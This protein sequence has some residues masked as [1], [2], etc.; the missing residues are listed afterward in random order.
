MDLHKSLQNLVG[1]H[2]LNEEPDLLFNA[3]R[4]INVRGTQQRVFILE[5]VFR[6]I[7]LPDHRAFR[8]HDEFQKVLHNVK[9]VSTAR[10]VPAGVPFYGPSIKCTGTGAPTYATKYK[11]VKSQY[12]KDQPTITLL[13][14][15]VLL[16]H[17][18]CKYN[19]SIQARCVIP[20]FFVF[21]FASPRLP[22]CWTLCQPS[23]SIFKSRSS[24][25][26]SLTVGAT[27]K[28]A[29]GRGRER[30]LLKNRT[31]FGELS[32]L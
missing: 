21:W 25:R 13:G 22:L 31:L 29:R 26:F 23:P 19:I 8:S 5:V 24:K 3:E 12:N 2:G 16:M 1:E 11:V 28:V 18:P 32:I 4:I 10:G 20:C 27:T 17:M 7:L 14:F 15:T 6:I 30:K 9:E